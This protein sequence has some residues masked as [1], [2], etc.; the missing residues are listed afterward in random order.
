MLERVDG[1]NLIL[2]ARPFT[3]KLLRPL[4]V[5]PDVWI[6]QLAADFDQSF[7]LGVVVKDTP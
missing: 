4:R 2:E 7:I 1:L 6:F 5:V 3:P